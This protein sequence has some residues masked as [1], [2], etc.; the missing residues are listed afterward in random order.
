M[1]QNGYYIGIDPGEHTGVAVWDAARQEFLQVE[2]LPLHRA[3]E[4]VRQY[5]ATPRPCTVICEDARKRTWFPQERNN[6]EY[7]GRLMGA[8][9][10]KR[11][12]KIWEEFLSDLPGITFRM[13][14]PQIHGTKWNAEQFK[15]YTGYAG[16]TNEHTRD[17]A[18]LVYGRH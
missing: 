13:T 10:A 4:L 18:L 7:R 17:A 14:R 5:A 1:K 15:Q 2:A 11:D 16:R 9:A 12:A 3:F 8:G 6:S